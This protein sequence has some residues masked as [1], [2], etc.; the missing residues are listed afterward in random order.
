MLGVLL[1]RRQARP[2]SLV[3]KD[4]YGNVTSRTLV[5]GISANLYD[6]ELVRARAQVDRVAN[7][8]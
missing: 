7:G 4:Y 3:R 6:L 2:N 5:G 1:L 8:K